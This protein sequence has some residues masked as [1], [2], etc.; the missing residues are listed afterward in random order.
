MCATSTEAIITIKINI[1]TSDFEDVLAPI[2]IL[3]CIKTRTQN[4]KQIL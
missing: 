3:S 1:F 2:L 4:A